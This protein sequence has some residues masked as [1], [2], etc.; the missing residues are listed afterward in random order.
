MIALCP[1]TGRGFCGT[2]A[3]LEMV[4][5]SIGTCH[6]RARQ[7]AMF[8]T[9][10]DCNRHK[11]F[12]E[13]VDGELG[14]VK[15]D[16]RTMPMSSRAGAGSSA[17]VGRAPAD[18]LMSIDLEMS[19]GLGG[20]VRVIGVGGAGGNAVNR[21]IEAGVT[22][23]RFIAVNTDTQALGRC[24]APVRLHLGKPGSARDGA[25]GNPEVGMRAAESVIEDIDALVAGADMVFITAGMG[26]GTGTGA[27]GVIG[28]R[29]KAAGALTVG[30]VSLPFTFEGMRRR[31]LAEEGVDALREVVDAL[32]VVPN[33][34]LLDLD[35]RVKLTD[36]FKV[37]DDMLRHGVQGISDLVTITG[38]INLDFADVRS[39]MTNAGTAVMAIGE[40][41]GPNRTSQA[42]DSIISNPLLE[43]S[44]TG[45]SSVLLNITG[46]ADIPVHEVMEICDRIKGVCA[47]DVNFFFGAVVH[48]GLVPELRVTLIATGM[49]TVGMTASR[50]RFGRRAPT[51]TTRQSTND[52]GLTQERTSPV[53][54]EHGRTRGIG[55]GVDGDETIVQPI[56]PVRG[57]FGQ[58]LATDL[59]DEVAV[60]SAGL[61]PSWD[62]QRGGDTR[63]RIAFPDPGAV[64]LPEETSIDSLPPFLRRTR[65]KGRPSS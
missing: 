35:H 20:D 52:R 63:R 62:E 8:G 26:G 46:P 30:V 21:M 3:L 42:V 33:D 43:T 4:T 50:D 25:G 6:S 56:V 47:S 49:P 40:G 53:R 65:D 41:Q 57:A 9:F 23:V 2:Q 14:A 48:A 37:A 5:L 24:E 10:C 12:R 36:G 60:E 17:R 64:Y 18:P 11:A 45:A 13:R 39:V 19:P 44:I 1:V 16:Q 27:S 7:R 51:T 59:D 54:E 38:L 34:R 31:K 28:Q 61:A 55:W 58:S 22:G 15:A 32:I 29:A